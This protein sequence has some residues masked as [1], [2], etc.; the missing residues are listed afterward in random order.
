MGDKARLWLQG[1]DS[2]RSVLVADIEEQ[3]PYCPPI[4][5]EDVDMDESAPIAEFGHCLTPVPRTPDF[6]PIVVNG[7]IWVNELR[8]V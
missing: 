2:V 1:L 4:K 8:H 7:R 3:P 5:A 6:G